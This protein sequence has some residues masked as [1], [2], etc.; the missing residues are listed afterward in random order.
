AYGTA[1]AGIEA[2]SEGW[3]PLVSGVVHVPRDDLAALSRT[4]EEME[5]RVA[6]F[7]GEPVQG[8]AGVFPPSDQYSTPLEDLCREHGCLLMADEVVTGFGRLGTW[9][10]SQR[11]DI[12]PDLMILAKGLS[13][14]YSPVGA[15]VATGEIIDVLWAPSAGAFRHGYTY[16]GHPAS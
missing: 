7:I 9:F 15:V 12:S 11:Y 3:G 10:G 14:G 16:S 4:L 8:A 2:N 13:S 1:L 6:A 5:G